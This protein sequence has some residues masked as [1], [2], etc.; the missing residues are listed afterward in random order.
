MRLPFACGPLACAAIACTTAHATLINFDNLAGGVQVT[1]Q[2]PGVTFS[3]DPGFGTYTMGG[4]PVSYPY[5]LCTAPIGS[6]MDCIQNVFIDF[7]S[8]VVNVSLWAVEPNEYGTVATFF[9]YNGASL[10]A[11]HNLIG[12][13]GA[14]NTFGYGNLFIDLSSYGAITR[15]EIRGPGGSGFID[16]SAGG[17]GIGWD[18]LSYEV[19]TPTTLA[20]LALAGLLANRRR[21]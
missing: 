16:S 6:E 13:A 18:D 12:L 14:P 3:S 20:P 15:L 19:P 17:N 5:F 9:L 1:N 8:P 2:Y 10:I 7:A 11:T 21:R 4:T